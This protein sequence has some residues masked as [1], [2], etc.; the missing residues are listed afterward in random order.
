LYK[1]YKKMKKDDLKILIISLLL[2]ALIATLTGL[3]IK[4]E[5][6]QKNYLYK[7]FAP[8]STSQFDLSKLGDSPQDKQIRYGYELISNTAKYLGSGAKDG[9]RYAGNDL[10][11]KSCHLKSGTKA[12]SMPFVGVSGRFPQF[13]GRENRVETLNGRI[14]GCIER[15]LN[16]KALPSSSEEMRA[17][18]A[19]MD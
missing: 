6:I 7:I 11:C 8:E 9:M 12:F 17:M 15:S 14:N 4:Y 1:L 2:A 13:L 19:Y 3:Y 5:V 10:S 16:G 18:V